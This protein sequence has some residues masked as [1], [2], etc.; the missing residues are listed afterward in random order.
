MWSFK[1]NVK[2]RVI[3]ALPNTQAWSQVSCYASS[4]LTKK[5]CC[6]SLFKKKFQMLGNI[7]T[8]ALYLSS[9]VVCIL[10]FHIIRSYLKNKPLGLQTI[11][12][13]A[14]IL[15]TQVATIGNTG[16]SFGVLVGLWHF[17]FYGPP[18]HVSACI[19][20]AISWTSTAM[21]VFS[22]GFVFHQ[23]SANIPWVSTFKYIA[24]YFF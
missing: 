2:I 14:I 8:A 13:K 22:I 15:F 5:L 18:S 4:F 16:V 23:V 11:L 21:V 24:G 1:L 3:F 6:L 17:S 9:N 19:L 7:A 10:T 20:F 12:D